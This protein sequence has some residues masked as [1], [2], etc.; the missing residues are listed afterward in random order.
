MPREKFEF[1]PIEKT[2]RPLTRV[3]LLFG[4]LKEQYK[5]QV[6]A[7]VETGVLE[8][9][10][11][12]KNVGYLDIKGQE[13]P[14][15]SYDEI[16]ARMEPQYELIETKFKQGFTQLN[17]TAQLIPLSF[18]TDRVRD[19]ILKARNEGRLKDTRGNELDLNK[20][21]PCYIA[22]EYENADVTGDLV[23]FVTRY[24]KEGHGG[25]TKDELEDDERLFKG[26]LISLVEDLPNQ[27]RGKVI[28]GRRQLDVNQS[29]EQYLELLES[30]PQYFRESGFTPEQ[31]LTYF[32]INLK[33]GRII[34][35][36]EGPGKSNWNL[37]GYLKSSELVSACHW[38]RRSR[39][40]NL[41]GFR[42]FGHDAFS[43]ARSSVII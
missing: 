35:D 33:Q 41:S 11:D 21:F 4:N 3:E 29:A 1:K 36:Q 31:W 14:L 2:E 15:P 28:N 40:A 37:A 39:Q 17:L 18:L 5:T 13:K 9:M 24:A 38:D 19:E 43:G 42:E 22:S 26:Y 34:D 32:M 16:I 23:Y 30:D 12:G 8:L 10:S 20:K 7:L 6:T 27:G 25:L